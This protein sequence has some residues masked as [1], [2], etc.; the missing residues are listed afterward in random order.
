MKKKLKLMKQTIVDL[1]SKELK[2]VKGGNAIFPS[3][4]IPFCQTFLMIYCTGGDDHVHSEPPCDCGD[5]QTY[6][7]VNTCNTDC[8]D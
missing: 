1:D 7:K 2:S 3:Y 5:G 6:Y 8:I 4:M